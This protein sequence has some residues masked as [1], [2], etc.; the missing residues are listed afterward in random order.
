MDS[1][2]SLDWWGGLYSRLSR[3]LVY[4]SSVLLFGM[5]TMILSDVTLRYFFNS[6]LAAS[7]EISQL[8]EPWVIF[9]PFAYTLAIGGHVQVT[10]VTMRLPAR[11]R[12]ACDIFAY[13]VDFLFFTVLCYFSWLE[14]G[15]SLAIGE[16]MLASIRLPWWAGKL[17][18][19]LGSLFIGLQCIFQILSTVKEIRGK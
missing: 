5:A 10:L 19:P 17:A 9:L 12:L 1:V 14:F 6:P 15:H 3:F 7:V 13:T 8:I 16:I 18:M 4:L 2:V 11:W